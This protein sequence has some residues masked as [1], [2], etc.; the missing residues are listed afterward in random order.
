MPWDYVEVLDKPRLKAQTMTTANQKYIKC[1]AWTTEQ[2]LYATGPL[3]RI[4]KAC[5]NK[6]SIL[7]EHQN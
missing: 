1:L 2:Q 5:Q 4:G 6:H 3:Q 7:C